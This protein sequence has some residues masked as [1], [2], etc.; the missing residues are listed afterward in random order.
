M[1]LFW[2]RRDIQQVL[3]EDR[4]ELAQ[5]HE[6]QPCFS[7]QQREELE[8]IHSWIHEGGL[9]EAIDNQVE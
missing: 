1:W 8:E 3:Q 9:P 4:D 6:G 2:N 5:R 7:E